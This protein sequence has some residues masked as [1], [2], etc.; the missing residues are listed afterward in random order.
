MAV[1]TTRGKRRLGRY[2]R[3]LMERAG[4]EPADVAKQA[5]CARQT[6]TRLLTGHALPRVHLFMIILNVLQVTEDE[7]QRALKL[8]EVADADTTTI[9]HAHDLPVS[10]M[11]FRM[12]EREAW[13]ERT[14][15]AVIVPG[16]LQAPA[17][18]SAKAVGSRALTHGRW[19]PEREAAERRDR[20]APLRREN[21]PLELH[22]LIDEAALHRMIGGPAVMVEQLDHL[23]AM[24]EL[25]HV[26][27]QVIPFDVGAH[28]ALSGPLFILSF[29][30]DDE[31]DSAYVESLAGMH[32]VEK[33]DLVS[34]L[35]A[36]WDGAAGAALP[37]D[38]SVTFIRSARDAVRGT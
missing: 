22:S 7:R 9:E 6:V 35:S 20:Q 11:R 19:D 1:G 21:S 38:E 18:A 15:D 24:A 2:I 31:P 28:G 14:L 17:Y 13:R 36:V 5:L 16:L 12:D 23:L 25:P 37:P 32:T 26:T 34:A 30:E 33:P 8:W 10:Y 4:L 27:I 3:P 29:P